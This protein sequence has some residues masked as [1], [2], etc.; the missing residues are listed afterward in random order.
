MAQDSVHATHHT[1]LANWW[2]G[3]KWHRTPHTRHNT[4]SGHAGEQEQSGPGHQTRNTKHP[5]GTPVN[6]SQG[7]QNAV[8]ATQNTEQAH[9]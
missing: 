6:R 1:E 7:A 4:T 5:A 8:H 9:R 3:A 2:T